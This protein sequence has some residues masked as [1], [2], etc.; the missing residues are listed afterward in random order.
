MR[1]LLVVAALLVPLAGSAVTIDW[2]LV[3]DPGNAPDTASNCV[4]SAPNCGSVGYSYYIS[5]YERPHGWTVA[6]TPPRWD[7]DPHGTRGL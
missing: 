5:K 7:G 4:N 1:R 2:V 6:P 3:G